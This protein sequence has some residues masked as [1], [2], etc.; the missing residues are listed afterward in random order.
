MAQRNLHHIHVA[1][2]YSSKSAL[3]CNFNF[4]KPQIHPTFVTAEALFSTAEALA[5]E[6]AKEDTPNCKINS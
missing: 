6:V 5:K 4:Q 2:Y 1:E 3:S